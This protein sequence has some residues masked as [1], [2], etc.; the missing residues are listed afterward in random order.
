MLPL[1]VIPILILL[2]LLYKGCYC[3][4]SMYGGGK[5]KPKFVIREEISSGGNGTVYLAT[6]GKKKFIYKLERMD[7]Y[8]KKKPLESEYYR[9]LKFDKDIS[10][11][12]PNKFLTIKDHSIIKNCDYVHPR[13]E[14]FLDVWSK[15][16]NEHRLQ[17]FKRKNSQPDCYYLL[18]SPFLDGTFPSIRGKI[19]GN[20]D[21]FLDFM[22]Q[23]IDSLNIVRKAGYSQNDMSPNNI[24]YKKKDDEDKYQWYIIDYGNMYNKD[25]PTSALDRD[26][27]I[28]PKYGLDL[29][30]FCESVIM[31]N[32]REWRM[33]IL[34]KG[35]FKNNLNP[36]EL[37]EKLAEVPESEYPDIE[38]YT[39]KKIPKKLY[40]LFINDLLI[41]LYPKLFL[42]LQGASVELQDSYYHTIEYPELIAYCLLHYDDKNYNGILKHIE[43]I[44]TKNKPILLTGYA[45]SGKSTLIK[46]YIKEG[47]YPINLDEFIRHKIAP[48]FAD[49]QHPKVNFFGAIYKDD[50]GDPVYKKAVSTF[51]KGIK[52]TI[53]EHNGKVVIEGQLKNHKLIREIFG[54]NEDFILYVVQPK[55]V[56]TWA[57]R[58]AS[59]WDED[60]K[61][62]GRLG[63]LAIADKAQDN[64]AMND[65]LKNGIN[66]KIFQDFI[67][68]IAKERFNKHKEMY[69]SFIPNFDV[70]LLVN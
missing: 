51:V 16:G 28:R 17:R 64:I 13:T 63:F 61:Q 36:D 37:I 24:M 18:C 48:Q 2:Y 56:S 3:Y 53:K 32:Y 11:K 34:E 1:L 30:Q 38:K 52:N 55:D 44:Y 45:A 46:K 41:L 69:Q 29:F 19:L 6:I 40:N 65:Y 54:N 58:L 33:S 4:P 7:V 10:Q 66:G 49:E 57:R 27:Q 12:H 42:K 60:P 39:P 26:I 9:Q 62:Y 67:L 31:A 70:K 8:D 47:Y 22:Y 59:R 43:S 68:R 21:L 23:I 14:E 20:H 50:E 5:K 15:S 35:L 25:F